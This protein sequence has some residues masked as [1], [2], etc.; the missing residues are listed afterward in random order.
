[1]GVNDVEFNLPKHPTDRIIKT[2]E[3]TIVLN[4]QLIDA[5]GSF[6]LDV[7]TGINDTTFLEG[8]YS[9]SGTVQ[10]QNIDTLMVV[11]PGESVA[12]YVKSKRNFVSIRAFAGAPSLNK[13]LTYKIMLV[14]K[15]DQ[16]VVET[17][18]TEYETVLT[19]KRNYRKI[20][21]EDV[22]Q[23]FVP[24]SIGLPV[25]TYSST[26]IDI[27]HGLGYYPAVKQYV[28]YN[29]EIMSPWA[30]SF[31]VGLHYLQTIIGT[32]KITYELSTEAGAVT[33]ELHYRIY[34]DEH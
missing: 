34:Y 25:G 5:L 28:E 14:A 22:I 12:I 27:V 3:G 13:I 9:V 17:K 16:K 33:I 6:V 19:S 8:T 24:T 29:D 11:A 20:F 23:M 1:M 30:M 7:P 18:D 4:Q 2:L 10:D 15:K 31:F 26:N 32:Q 21:K